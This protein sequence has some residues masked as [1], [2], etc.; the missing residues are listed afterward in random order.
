MNKILYLL[1]LLCLTGCLYKTAHN[2]PNALVSIQVIDRNGF[3]E[4]ISSRDRL[5]SYEK[6]DFDNPQPYQKVL[7]VFG[8]DEEGKTQSKITSYHPNGFIAQSLEVYDGRAHGNYREWYQNGKLK[9]HA[10]VIEGIAD[11]NDMAKSNWLFEGKSTVWDEE[12]RLIAE[13]NYEKGCL[14]SP[15]FYYH[16]NGQLWKSI[17]Y[18]QNQIEG[19]TTVF[20]ED[21]TFLEKSEYRGGL[22][23]GVS[24]GWW[25]PS[26]PSFTE[27]YSKGLLQNGEYFNLENQL[28]AE[29][30]EG[31]GI[32]AQ[33]E[34]GKLHSFTEYRN[35]QPDGLVRNFSE[36]GHLKSSYMVKDG[37]KNGEELKYYPGGDQPKLSISWYED[38]IQ[39]LVKTWYSNGTQES[40]KEMNANKKQGLCFAWYKDGSLMLAE[41]YENDTLGKGTYYKRGDKSPVSK[42]DNGKG[43]ATL[44]D[45]EGRLLK[46]IPYEKGKPSLD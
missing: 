34:A 43:T 17:P 30:K 44:F 38:I 28:V 29:V 37:K 1:T 12:G 45:S 25:N 22:K 5:S 16:P 36:S 14:E 2:D 23:E 41:E 31:M 32:Q 19:T 4:T 24:K 33:F 10:F 27:L 3:T 8:R 39:G 13:I 21:G 26:K 6:V 9:L 35:G 42:I 20:A 15:S 11:I 18:R 40:Q 7:R 46:K